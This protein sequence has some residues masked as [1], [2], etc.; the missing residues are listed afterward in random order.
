MFRVNVVQILSSIRLLLTTWRPLPLFI[1]LKN[2]TVRIVNRNDRF[3]EALTDE[4]LE[5]ILDFG[6]LLLQII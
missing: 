2:L 6:L 4:S 1:L 5:L 3:T